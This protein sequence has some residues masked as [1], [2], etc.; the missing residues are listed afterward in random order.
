MYYLAMNKRT[1]ATGATGP[2][3][4]AYPI[5]SGGMGG[6]GAIGSWGGTGPAGFSVNAHP[7]DQDINRYTNRYTHSNG[8][9]E[10]CPKIE[11][12]IN[13]C[14]CTVIQLQ[15]EMELLLLTQQE[16]EQTIERLFPSYGRFDMRKHVARL[17]SA[18]HEQKSLIEELCKDIIET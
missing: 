12:I 13:D 8:H 9:I 14:T 17:R 4:I 7:E 18:V 10:K 5:A 1:P 6:S 11:T 15:H 3:G 2:T 16:N